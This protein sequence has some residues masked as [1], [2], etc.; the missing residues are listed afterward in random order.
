MAP[1]DP[2]L[3]GKNIIIFADAEEVG[4]PIAENGETLF[5]PDPRGCSHDDVKVNPKHPR[6]WYFQLLIDSLEQDPS[7]K[8]FRRT[9]DPYL[10]T[11][12]NGEQNSSN[13]EMGCS[14]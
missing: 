6:A 4:N 2:S 10:D 8:H 9:Y 5:V 3:K 7:G 14:P 12:R 11:P 1:L 13:E